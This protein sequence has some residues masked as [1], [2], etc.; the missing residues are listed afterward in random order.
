MSMHQ[1]AVCQEETMSVSA[2]KGIGL[3]QLPHAHEAHFIAHEAYLITNDSL[4]MRAISDEGCPRLFMPVAPNQQLL[5]R[6]LYLHV[7]LL[8]CCSTPSPHSSLFPSIPSSD[9]TKLKTPCCA[10]PTPQCACTFGGAG[11]SPQ[12]AT[13]C[14][15][16]CGGSSVHAVSSICQA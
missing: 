1:M 11:L 9:G 4:V 13:W 3:D 2:N 5:C 6:S 8:E 12:A 15:N 10:V 14:C 7:Q 16:R